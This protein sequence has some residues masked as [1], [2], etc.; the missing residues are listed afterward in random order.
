MKELPLVALSVL[1]TS[2][3]GG[4][5]G[6]PSP[7]ASAPPPATGMS[8]TSPA[9][10]AAMT[11]NN[12][13]GATSSAIADANGGSSFTVDT[14]ANGNVKTFTLNISTGGITKTIRL[15]PGSAQQV[16]NP[17]AA[18]VVA[19]SLN[20]STFGTWGT[21]EDNAGNFKFGGFAGGQATP[22]AN[23]P[24]TGSAVYNGSMAGTAT[25]GTNV[26]S[27]V[28]D[29]QISANFDAQTVGTNFFNMTKQQVGTNVMIPV[30]SFS[31][32]SQLSGNIYAGA[33]A[34]ANGLQTGDVRGQ[35][36][37]PGAQET[38]GVWH[39]TGA[40]TTAVGSFGAH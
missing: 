37:G 1:L 24:R 36:Y 15:T 25:N 38:A 14:D 13:S 40:G 12:L 29:A 7:T 30:T 11:F 4:G 32:T 35:F 23:M 17:G 6:S 10:S 26:F 5:G 34:A 21:S 39:I 20:F 27:V 2:C 9:A 33:L 3:G 31:G 8:T 16:G 19:Q 28:G 22:I 18:F